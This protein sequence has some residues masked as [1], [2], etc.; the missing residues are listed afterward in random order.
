MLRTQTRVLEN[1]APLVLDASLAEG[2]IA[3]T[4]D[5]RLRVSASPPIPFASALQGLLD[6]PYGCAEQTTSKAYAALVMDAATAQR[7]G[8]TGLDAATRRARLEGALGRLAA[9]QAGSGHFSMW[10]GD[11]GGTVPVLTPY[12]VDFLLD[13]REAGFAVPDGVL[14]KALDRLSEDLLAGGE[15][16]YGSDHRD[17]LR[18]ANR[19]Y[20]GYV[21]A[22]VNRAPLGTLRALYDH[23]KGRQ[24]DRPAAGPAGPTGAGPAGRWQ[25]RCGGDRRRFRPRSG[26]CSGVAGRLQQPRPRRRADDRAAARTRPRGREVRRARG[27]PGAGRCRCAATKTA[28]AGS[29]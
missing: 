1:A 15:Q 23:K 5:V 19:A 25:A 18:F 14:Q 24:P 4:V 13:A 10:G 7:L 29:G 27:G 22:R 20:A 28:A 21:L 12:I 3:D 8:S 9:M 26:R 2:L 16:F 6:Y 11:G 17:H